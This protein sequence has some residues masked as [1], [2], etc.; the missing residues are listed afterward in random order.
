MLP[1]LLLFV[2]LYLSI[3]SI[4]CEVYFN[5]FDMQ[6][7]L[8]FLFSSRRQFSPWNPWA[9]IKLGFENTCTLDLHKRRDINCRAL[10]NWKQIWRNVSK[11][12]LYTMRE[13]VLISLN[14]I[15]ISNSSIA[16]ELLKLQTLKSSLTL[17]RLNKAYWMAI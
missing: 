12:A 11:I 6:K 9:F 3:I 14:F 16:I 5:K 1:K 4:I 17:K 13:K 10:L 2:F 8:I 7:Q 15:I